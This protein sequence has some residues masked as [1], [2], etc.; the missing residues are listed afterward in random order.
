MYAIKVTFAELAIRVLNRKN[1][2]RNTLSGKKN[3]SR[4]TVVKKHAKV[5]NPP[6]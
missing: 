4:N 3:G 5:F 6:L 1:E 2:F